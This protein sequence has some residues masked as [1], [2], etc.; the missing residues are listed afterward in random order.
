MTSDLPMFYIT[1]EM[2]ITLQQVYLL[3]EYQAFTGFQQLFMA[4]QLDIV[5]FY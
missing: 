3:V 2:T 5:T 4:V 1:R